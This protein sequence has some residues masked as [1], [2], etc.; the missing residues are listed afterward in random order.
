[1]RVE[2]EIRINC[3]RD[4]SVFYEEMVESLPSKTFIL[5]TTVRNDNYDGT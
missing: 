5:E 3:V 4:S 1:M 2:E